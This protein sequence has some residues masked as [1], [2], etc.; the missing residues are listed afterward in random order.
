MGVFPRMLTST[1]SPPPG[2]F[3]LFRCVHYGRNPSS[4]DR[5]AH[6]R[7]S[8]P[9]VRADLPPM[10]CPTTPC[11]VQ[12][13][14]CGERSESIRPTFRPHR[15]LE[16]LPRHA[17]APG[18]ACLTIHPPLTLRKDSIMAVAAHDNIITSPTLIRNPPLIR[19]PKEPVI[20]GGIAPRSRLNVLVNYCWRK[21]KGVDHGSRRHPL[22]T[23]QLTPHPFW[24]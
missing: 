24:G 5:N 14:A 8:P 3:L 10:A 21:H 19:L 2:R 12:E 6:H 11:I 23:Q 15:R 4:T 22:P 13:A 9:R 17:S 7:I 20:P 16:D 1:N 18:Q